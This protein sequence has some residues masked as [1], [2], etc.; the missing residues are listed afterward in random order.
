MALHRF[1]VSTARSLAPCRVGEEERTLGFRRV[2]LKCVSFL[3]EAEGKLHSLNKPYKMS[4][5]STRWVLRGCTSRAASCSH[6]YRAL[7]GRHSVKT[8]VCILCG[9]CAAGRGHYEFHMVNVLS[10]RGIEHY[11]V[12]GAVLRALHIDSFRPPTSYEM[13]TIILLIL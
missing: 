11:S 2:S 8:R 5:A 12:S 6:V 1:R 7:N 9:V 4:P 3:T 10:L 13:E